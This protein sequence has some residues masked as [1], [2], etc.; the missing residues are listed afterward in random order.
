M[1]DCKI[2]SNIKQILFW[3]LPVMLFFLVMLQKASAQ[4]QKMSV[5]AAFYNCEN[6]F[7]T[8]DDSLTRD[9]EF[10][11]EGARHWDNRRF[12]RKVN[13]TF[14]VILA[15]G[16]PEPPALVG[17]C[18]IENRFVLNKLV[19]ETPLKQF[20]YR[21]I[22]FESPDRRGIDV[23]L[24]YRKDI[25][26]PLYSEPVPVRFPFDT[27]SR[28]RDILYVKG[29]LLNADTIH[30]FV[31]HWPSRYGGYL[32]TVPK[33]KQAA[34]TLRNKTDSVLRANPHAAILIMGDFNDGPHD[35][36][37]AE[38]LQAKNPVHADTL[39]NLYNLMLLKQKDWS[40]GSLKY[41][42]G[43]GKFDQI[44]VSGNLL[45]QDAPLHVAGNKAFIFHAPFLLEEDKIYLGQRLN[46]T[47]VGFKYHGGFSDHLPVYVD[48]IVAVN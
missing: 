43:W 13:H 44:I 16:N 37:F 7:D 32:P 1:P 36:S 24:L 20:G 41:R 45:R 47:Y 40:Y 23:A 22:Q 42:E 5:R 14:K 26:E 31:N 2:R 35:A 29:V 28:T 9:D 25:F 48:L 11:P 27:A 6:F 4:E 30:I 19:Y 15:L 10:T 34:E 21:I 8:Y 12:Y 39:T 17:L 38:V 46:R 18:E 3:Y 33:R